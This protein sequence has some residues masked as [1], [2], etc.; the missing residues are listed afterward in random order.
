MM[1]LME[2]FSNS[3]LRRYSGPSTDRVDMRIEF[4]AVFLVLIVDA[5]KKQATQHAHSA[6]TLIYGD[7]RDGLKF[8]VHRPAVPFPWGSQRSP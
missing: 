4:S 1:G 7:I 8:T 6:V 2:T 3:S 5:G